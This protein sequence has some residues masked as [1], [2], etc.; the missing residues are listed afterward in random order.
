MQL[1]ELDRKATTAFEGYVVRKDLVRTFSRQFPVPTYVV[2]FLLGRYCAT[3]DEAEIQ[4]GL[5]IVQRQL[6]SRTVKAGEEELFKARARESG[7][8]KIIDIITARLDSKTDSYVASLPSLRLNDVRLTPEM[9]KDNERMLTGGFY[10]EVTLGYDASIAQ[11]KGGRPFGVDGLR[12]IQLS[13][14]EVLGCTC[15][16]ARAVHDRRMARPAA[17]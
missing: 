8:V 14:R 6:G 11:E 12:A 1:D 10:A 7:S 17:A 5:D 2:E 13:K 15:Q 9:V 16:G 3:T 4:E